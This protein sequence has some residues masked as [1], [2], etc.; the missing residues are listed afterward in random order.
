MERFGL[1]GFPNSGKSS[2]FN[3]LTGSSA[4]AAPFP[5][6]TKEAHVGMAAVP[7]KRLD[8]LAEMSG[9]AK[10]TPA[11]VQFCD[12]GGIVEGASQGEGL[13]N[14]L[15]SHIREVEAIVYVLQA[16]ETEDLPQEHAPLSQLHILE[17]ELSLA[18]FD[19]T[20]RQLERREKQARS[21][22]SMREEVALLEK[23]AR[24]LA[25]GTPIYRSE[26]SDEEKAALAANFLLTNKPIM[27]LAN[28]GEEILEAETSQESNSLESSL[29]T[30]SPP[31]SNPQEEVPPQSHGSPSNH[32]LGSKIT[33]PLAKD[34]PQAEVMGMCV[35]LEEEVAQLPPE[36][37]AEMLQELGLG[38]GALA[39]FA[40]AAR[41]LLS[42]HTFFTTGEKESR[43]WTFK[44]GSTARECAGAIHTD[45]EKGFIRAETIACEDLL[46][47]GSWTAAKQAG[48]I[49]AEGRDYQTQDGDVMEFRF[50][51]PR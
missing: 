22:P 47:I 4:L 16:F 20:Q 33:S 17:M 3:A 23:A 18:D 2:L 24:V 29:Q 1:V 19:S 26:L 36:E 8:L 15:L 46:A 38:E 31:A 25:E 42:L 51:A 43:A 45:F 10:R 49:R 41:K 35:R 7:D 9:S 5:F 37:Q 32:L 48:K 13:G 40:R 30:D 11:Q 28:L 50:T 39:A 44:A 21:D 12:I 34:L 27:V 14:Q 6:A